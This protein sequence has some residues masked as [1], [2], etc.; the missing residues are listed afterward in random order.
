LATVFIVFTSF[1]FFLIQYDRMRTWGPGLE[2]WI[3]DILAGRLHAPDQYR[4]GL[5]LVIHFL[6][7]HTRFRANQLF[8]LTEFLCYALALT[9]LYLLFRCSPGIVDASHARRFVSLGFFFTAAQFPILWIFPWERPET[10]PTALYLAAVVVLIACRSR[11]PFA[12]VCLLVALLSL[13][14]A[15]MRTDVPVAFAAAIL[16]CAAMDVPL[17]RPRLHI[18]ILGLLS[19]A[20]GGAVQLY[21]QQ[22]AYP[23]STY[24]PTTPRFQLLANLNPV[25]PPMHVPIFLTALLPLVVS[26]VLLR[27]YRLNLDSSD[28]LVLLLLAVY[29]PVWVAMGLVAEVRIFV[30]FLFLASPT[31]AKLWGS[32][33]LNERTNPC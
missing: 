5:P 2:S 30:P 9:L 10:L 31:V 21:L 11:M 29:L 24:P 25:Y 20:I 33:L 8:P 13:G 15:L 6:E 16:L 17:P 22:V 12:V 23:S 27:R 14:E 32:F 3:Q 19:G 18:A 7:L 26:L 1:S 28:K 4:I